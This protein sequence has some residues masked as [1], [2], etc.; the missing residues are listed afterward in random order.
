MP[1]S[2]A[3]KADVL[4][5]SSSDEVLR[6]AEILALQQLSDNVARL[7][8]TVE[9]IDN[10]LDT[11]RETVTRLEAQELKASIGEL[12]TDLL[13]AIGQQ[14]QEFEE[15]LKELREDHDARI[16]ELRDDHEG[17][18]KAAEAAQAR[19]HTSIIWLRALFVPLSAIGGGLIVFLAQ[20]AAN[21]LSGVGASVHRL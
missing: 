1:P 4:M 19:D 11:V 6:R 9:K 8:N 13:H 17:R 15:R 21:V 18:L 20:W 2:R 5:S 10:R 12:K 3:P 14:R 7:N 16:K